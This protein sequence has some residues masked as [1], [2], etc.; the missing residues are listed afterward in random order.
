MTI[1]EK[2][3]NILQEIHW[4]VVT[5]WRLQPKIWTTTKQVWIV[6]MIVMELG[7]STIAVGLTWMGST[8]LIRQIDVA[9]DGITGEIQTNH[10]SLL[11]WK[12]DRKRELFF[13][14]SSCDGLQHSKTAI[15][16]SNMVLLDGWNFWVSAVAWSPI[17]CRYV[18][19]LWPRSLV[20]S[21]N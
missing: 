15:V 21:V 8:F 4:Q 1:D 14:Q 19:C 20:L 10:S 2:Q 18:L 7:G 3:K 5:S 16:C 17:Y 12:W 9:W 11:K 13:I 6:L